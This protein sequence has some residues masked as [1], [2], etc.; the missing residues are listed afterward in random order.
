MNWRIN[1]YFIFCL[2]LLSCSTQK[3]EKEQSVDTT[4]DGYHSRRYLIEAEDLLA[5]YQDSTIKIIDFQARE[6]L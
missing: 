5:A 3:A 2:A 4:P 1:S 6:E